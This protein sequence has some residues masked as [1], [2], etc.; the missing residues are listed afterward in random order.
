MQRLRWI[1]THQV[2]QLP[3]ERYGGKEGDA[4]VLFWR[5]FKIY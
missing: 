1:R 5:V 3:G 2:P 4:D